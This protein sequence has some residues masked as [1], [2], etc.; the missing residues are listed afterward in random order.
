MK[1]I[2][3]KQVGLAEFVSVL[4]EEQCNHADSEYEL[5]DDTA[6]VRD[7][8]GLDIDILGQV[9]IEVCQKCGA[10]YDSFESRWV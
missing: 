5:V 9:E 4:V 6:I 8:D 7:E 2:N 1:Q 10:Q 3:V